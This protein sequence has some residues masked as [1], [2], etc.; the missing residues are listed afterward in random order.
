MG[1]GGLRRDR[2]KARLRKKGRDAW[3]DRAYNLGRDRKND[4]KKRI[5]GSG[6]VV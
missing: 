5:W 6:E 3:C 1:R 4:I 2:G